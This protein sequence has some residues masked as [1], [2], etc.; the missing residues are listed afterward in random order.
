MTSI[1]LR[2]HAGG[3]AI[4]GHWNAHG[5]LY[6]VGRGGTFQWSMETE[7]SALPLAVAFKSRDA[8]VIAPVHPLCLVEPKPHKLRLG[9]EVFDVHMTVPKWRRIAT[10]TVIVG[11]V[12][13]AIACGWWLHS[14]ITS[15]SPDAA[16]LQEEMYVF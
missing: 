4:V 12:I 7:E 15:A 10:I 16:Q 6:L 2:P 14:L 1:E 9:M 11:A 5:L 13:A 8:V 3:P